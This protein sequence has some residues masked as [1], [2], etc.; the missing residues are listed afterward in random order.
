MVSSD[1][2]GQTRRSE[3]VAVDLLRE[4]T[5]VL[6]RHRT[7]LLGVFSVVTIVVAVGAMCTPLTY[8]AESSLLVR[9]GREYIYRPEVGRSEAARTP[10]LSEIVNS[11][12]EILASRDLA[13]LVVV[14]LG[15]DRL[16]PDM[17]GLGPDPELGRGKAVLRF[18]QATSVRAVL[19]SSVIKVGY[20]HEDPRLAADAVN[21]LV[22]RFKDKH[23][24]VFGEERSSGLEDQFAARRAELARAEEALADFKR[25]TGLFDL[26]KQRSVL[27]GQRMRLEEDFWKCEP[28]PVEGHRPAVEVG[29]AEPAAAPVFSAQRWPDSNAELV[30]IDGLEGAAP[31]RE[32]PAANG[33][34]E[35]AS[36]RLL[37]LQLDERELLRDY[38]AGSR[39][40]QSVRAELKL[41][42][43]FLEQAT[44]RAGTLDE[45]R[46]EALASEMA[47][48]DQR[49][50]SLHQQEKTLRNLERELTAAETAMLITRERVEE[51]RISQELDREKLIN[52]RVIEKAAPPVAPSGLSRGLKTFIGALVGL[53]TG[54]AL[55]VF[56]ELFRRR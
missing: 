29:V 55:A 50:E 10:S 18:R 42:Q 1:E 37:E 39:R 17:Q 32:P 22:E 11:E 2:P 28:R 40:V 33:V 47:D 9:M 30:W 16:Y 26:D 21:L 43:D 51:A 5:L 56:L 7:L 41:A 52:V 49:V 13:E 36:L 27:L 53:V 48:L 19:E 54:A 8:K 12:V 23:V 4:V 15:I 31:A 25:A 46:R 20:E 14:Q 35:E 24:E 45:V 44:A 3:P 38:S 34:I 6:A